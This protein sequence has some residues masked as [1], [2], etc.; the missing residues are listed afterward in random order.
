M[1]PKPV[2]V[3]TDG[4]GESLCAVEWAAAEAARRSVPLR[5]MSVMAIPAFVSSAGDSPVTLDDLMSS[6]YAQSLGDGRAGGHEVGSRG[7]DHHRTDDRLTEPP[8][9]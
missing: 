2:V 9:G 6:V 7:D 4:S 3:G 1:T 5:I 8:A